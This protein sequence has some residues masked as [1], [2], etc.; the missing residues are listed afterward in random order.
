MCLI[1]CKGGF[2]TR[3]YKTRNTK[4]IVDLAVFVVMP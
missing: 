3:P 1:S 2:Q 4:I